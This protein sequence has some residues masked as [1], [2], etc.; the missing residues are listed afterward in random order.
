M[1]GPNG[2]M[3]CF[4]VTG[5]YKQVA[6]FLMT[7]LKYD[8]GAWAKYA[9][10]KGTLI[11]IGLPGC[12]GCQSN[13]LFQIFLTGLRY[14]IDFVTWMCSFWLFYVNL[15]QSPCRV[16]HLHLF[17][18]VIYF[19]PCWHDHYASFSSDFLSILMVMHYAAV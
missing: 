18:S 2:N 1:P 15:F 10:K 12:C 7:N 6:Y 11:K 17:L 19:C 14:F 5:M 8:L 13:Y 9:L 3:V 16:C 4:V